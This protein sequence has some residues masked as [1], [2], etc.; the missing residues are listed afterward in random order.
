[1]STNSSVGTAGQPT[2]SW[3]D[4]ARKLSDGAPSTM[5]MPSVD[6]EKAFDRYFAYLLDGLW[7]NRRL[8]ADLNAAAAAAGSFDGGRESVV[9]MAAAAFGDLHLDCGQAETIQPGS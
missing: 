6:I 3:F 2:E 1:M 9:A 4:S 7:V 8:M 5:S